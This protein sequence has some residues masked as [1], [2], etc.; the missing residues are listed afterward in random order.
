MEIYKFSFFVVNI[1]LNYHASK[2]ESKEH[3]IRSR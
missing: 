3:I 2:Y 1:E